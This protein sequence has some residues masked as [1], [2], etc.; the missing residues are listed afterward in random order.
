MNQKHDVRSVVSPVEVRSLEGGGSVAVGY[1]ALF[2]TA[3]DIGG[4]WIETIARGAFASSLDGDVLALVDH[5]YGRVIG[6]SS[7]GTLRLS[8]DAKGLAVEIDLPDT[9]DGRDLAVQLKRGDISG[10]SF[11]FRVTHDE[12]DETVSPPK[13]TIHE[14]ELIEVSAVARPAYPDTELGLRSLEAARKERRSHNFSHAAR[15]LR[16]KVSL[17]LKG[18]E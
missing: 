13:R 15:R 12:W 14:V 18:R 17:D 16:M 2:D 11:G 3:A 5:D 8:E 4:W 10:M 1:A 6:R 7:A 9:T